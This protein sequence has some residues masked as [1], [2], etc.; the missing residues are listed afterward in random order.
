MTYIPH[1]QADVEAMLKTIGVKRIEDLFGV[2]P[3]SAQF[4]D[5]NLPD[6][7]SQME[8]GWIV[9]ELAGANIGAGAIA[10]FLGAGA[11]NHYIPSVVNHILLRG[12][13]MTAYTPY[14]PEVSQ[15]TLQ[16]IFEYQSMICQLTGMEVSN[17]SHYDGAG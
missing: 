4:P 14:Q 6:G 15:G 12:E 1:T 7:Y 17:A 8:T 11:Y 9:D 3:G 16:A 13:F 2:V 10:T 5:L